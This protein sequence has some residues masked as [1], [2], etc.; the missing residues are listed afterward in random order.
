[1]VAPDLE[2]AI[3]FASQAVAA[4]QAGDRATALAR[5]MDAAGALLAI[6]KVERDAAKAAKLAARMETY[7]GSPRTEAATR[8]GA[9]SRVSTGRSYFTADDKFR[10]DVAAGR[11]F[12]AA[13][14]K[15][16][17]QYVDDKFQGPAA[18][19]RD[20]Y[21][22]PA[23]S[24]KDVAGWGALGDC[25]LLSSLSVLANFPELVRRLVWAADDS[26]RSAAGVFAARLCL[27][28]EFR[29]VTVGGGARRDGRPAF[30]GVDAGALWPAIVEKAAA[31]LHG[32]YGALD[33]GNAAEA[34]GL[35]TGLPTRTWPKIHEMLKKTGG[36]DELHGALVHAHRSGFIIS[37]S[38][39]FTG[40][41]ADEAQEEKI[42]DRVGLLNAHEY[43]V[44]RVVDVTVGAG[45]A[46]LVQLRNPWA[47]REWRGPWS[48]G[49]PEWAALP[50]AARAML[51][52]G[53]CLASDDGVFWMALADVA[54]YFHE[55]TVCRLR[56]NFAQVRW[57]VSSPDA[58]DA[59]T[60]AFRVAAPAG[61]PTTLDACLIQRTERGT[62][63][64]GHHVVG[65][66]LFLVFAEPPGAVDA[67]AGTHAFTRKAISAGSAALVHAG[68]EERPGLAP[69]VATGDLKL[70]PGR[71]YLLV[72]LCLNWRVLGI[73]SKHA[74]AA[75]LYS[76]RPLQ[77]VAAAGLAP[78]ALAAAVRAAVI[79]KGATQGGET[80]KAA[81]GADEDERVY[82][83][84]GI[85]VVENRR[86][87]SYLTVTVG[88][89]AARNLVSS[90]HGGVLDPSKPDDAYAVE[91]TLPPRSW[92][93]VRGEA[94]RPPVQPGGFHAC[95]PLDD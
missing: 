70:A 1:M 30:A 2:I 36:L 28:G 25:W 95:Y 11:A 29:V 69:V 65:D 86:R 35:L 63:P 18:L 21:A 40:L 90:R 47:K 54:K 32:S 13:A 48:R 91:D 51:D 22:L 58:L 66:A 61:E 38:C 6:V 64:R 17:G 72:P 87:S 94:H 23:H 68:V 27:A 52:D 62:T 44:L 67:T 85:Y 7:V 8:P 80:A 93:I 42:Y 46:R 81:P 20:G 55:V 89:G 84:D 82:E 60:P 45:K 49:G 59:P 31:K 24:A 16:G 10:S 53:R 9:R 5:Y 73:G 41:G 57:P 50:E 34:L 74:L 15:R 43:A 19:S 77:H 92:Q 12:C 14:E 78:D 79:A 83:L 33:S 75:V 56:R 4:D 88:L 76:S 39:G 3:N 37:A 71:A 26:G